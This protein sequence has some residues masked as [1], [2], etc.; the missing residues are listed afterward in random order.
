[1]INTLLGWEEHFVFSE[2]LFS[3]PF[4]AH[5]LFSRSIACCDTLHETEEKAHD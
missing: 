2:G 4:D 1:M 5:T 3:V